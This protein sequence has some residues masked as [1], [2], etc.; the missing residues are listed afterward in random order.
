MAGDNNLFFGGAQAINGNPSLPNS[1]AY[2]V[3]KVVGDIGSL[4][5][6]GGTIAGGLAG[7][8]G[9]IALDA[10]GVGAIAGVP[11]NIASAGAIAYGGTVVVN[12]AVNLYNDTVS[13]MS[14]NGG[15]SGFDKQRKGTP[16][17]NQ[18]QNKQTRDISNRYKLDKDQ[19][20]ELH[21]EI[22]GQNY[23]F[24]EIEEIAKEIAGRK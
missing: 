13:L 18:A 24:K 22:T 11:L 6:G 23:T 2:K 20:R 17:N 1:T 14:G 7:E 15:S 3:G 4:F 16:G 9:G 8:V 5:A 12:G 10:T 19:Q 21:D